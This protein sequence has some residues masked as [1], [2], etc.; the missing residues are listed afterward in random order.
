MSPANWSMREAIMPWR[1][2]TYSVRI[3]ESVPSW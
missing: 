3:R 2:M 1:G